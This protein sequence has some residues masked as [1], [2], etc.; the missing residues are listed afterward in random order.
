MWVSGYRS[1][2]DNCRGHSVVVDL[3]PENN[4]ENTGPTALELAVMA[5]AGCVVTIFRMV[6]EKRKLEYSDLVLEVEAEKGEK[7]VERCKGTLSICTTANRSEVEKALKLTLEICP[8]GV[9]FEK[10]GV[11]M[12]WEIKVEPQ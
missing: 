12:D 8:V 2:V 3:P 7:T 4:G 5:L 9:L 1:I 11:K 10:A 6:A